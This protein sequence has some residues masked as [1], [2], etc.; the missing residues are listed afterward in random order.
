MLRD[1]ELSLDQ[2]TPQWWIQSP[3]SQWTLQ[4][5]PPDYSITASQLHQAGRTSLNMQFASISK[6]SE[7]KETLRVLA[8]G[9]VSKKEF[10]DKRR[11]VATFLCLTVFHL[12][13]LSNLGYWEWHQLWTLLLKHFPRT[14]LA[15]S[16]LSFANK[17]SF[18]CERGII[19]FLSFYRNTFLA[20]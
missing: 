1:Q 2:M 18:N 9:R 7:R 14:K 12:W 20:R 8:V 4:P 11:A 17:G 19:W 10:L 6:S 13:H 3:Q 5:V 16:E 15:R